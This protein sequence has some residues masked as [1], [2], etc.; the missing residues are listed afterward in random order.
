[1]IFFFG[2]DANSSLYPFIIQ[3]M[4]IN[5]VLIRSWGYFARIIFIDFLKKFFFEKKI[6]KQQAVKRYW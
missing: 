4:Y 2:N 5:K 3:F 1:M 6:R